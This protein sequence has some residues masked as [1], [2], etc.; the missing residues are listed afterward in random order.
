MLNNSSNNL[1]H[2]QNGIMPL[3]SNCYSPSRSDFC[4]NNYN[5]LTGNTESFLRQKQQNFMSKTL[6]FSERNGNFF[7]FIKNIFFNF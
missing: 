6:N 7:L 4:A 5:T 2:L 3:A 1:N